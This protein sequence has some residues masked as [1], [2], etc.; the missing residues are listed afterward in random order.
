MNEQMLHVLV[1][2][3]KV[4]FGTTQQLFKKLDGCN[5]LSIILE[6]FQREHSIQFNETVTDMLQS[7]L[8]QSSDWCKTREF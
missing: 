8:M 6:T 3:K 2:S 1:P 7:Q 4:R 5:I